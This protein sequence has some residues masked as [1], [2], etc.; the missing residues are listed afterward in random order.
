MISIDIW[1]S[2]VFRGYGV[3]RLMKEFLKLQ[4]NKVW[5]LS[6]LT[7]SKKTLMPF[8]A[9]QKQRHPKLIFSL[10]IKMEFIR[11]SHSAQMDSCPFK[12]LY[13]EVRRVN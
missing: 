11:S 1:F 4:V 5:C 8:T 13:K 9:S 7:V 2:D 12:N 3:E 6:K 10:W